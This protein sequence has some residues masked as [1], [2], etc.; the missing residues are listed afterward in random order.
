MALQRLQAK[1]SYALVLYSSV[2]RGCQVA[3]CVD[4]INEGQVGMTWWPKDRVSGLRRL[5]S[6]GAR[7]AV[8][9]TKV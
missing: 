9:G 4:E 7:C 5:A 1:G 2:S 8:D 3:K 6:I